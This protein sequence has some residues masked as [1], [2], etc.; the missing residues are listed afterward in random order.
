MTP[1]KLSEIKDRAAASY[2]SDYHS[3]VF[4]LLDYISELEIRAAK[5]VTDGKDVWIKAKKI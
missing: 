5:I 4:A 1:E 3:D 2:Y